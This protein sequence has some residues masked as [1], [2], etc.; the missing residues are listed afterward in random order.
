MIISYYKLAMSHIFIP[1]FQKH[2]WFLSQMIYSP[3]LRVCIVISFDCLHFMKYARKLHIIRQR[4]AADLKST[5][6]LHWD[7]LQHT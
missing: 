6:L 2:I 1:N 7:P 4:T 3:F 5:S